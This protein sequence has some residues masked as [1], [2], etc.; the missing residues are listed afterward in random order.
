MLRN[1]SIM[2]DIDLIKQE[3]NIYNNW[4]KKIW[5]RI[6][7]YFK[8]T[9]LDIYSIKKINIIHR[10]SCECGEIVDIVIAKK[11]NNNELTLLLFCKSCL[12]QN[13]A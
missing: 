12:E 8:P 11:S 9:K 2:N 4:Y 10:I 3:Y 5:Y 1:I 7:Y 6:Y 13:S